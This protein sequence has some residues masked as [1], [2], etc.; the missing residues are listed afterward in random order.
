M[1]EGNI[2]ES[3]TVL[4]YLF[5]WK[6]LKISAGTDCIFPYGRTIGKLKKTGLQYQKADNQ[7]VIMHK[8]KTLC[9]EVQ[10]LNQSA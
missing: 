6:N 8:S 5:F 2:K 10:V 9:L 7:I 1:R 4:R 3:K